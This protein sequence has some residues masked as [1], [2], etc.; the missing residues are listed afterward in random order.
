MVF[1][2]RPSRFLSMLQQALR[3]LPL[4]GSKFRCSGLG[5]CLSL[6]VISAAFAAQR[7]RADAAPMDL[8][9]EEVKA[10]VAELLA[11]GQ[12]S[13]NRV[14]VW[15]EVQAVLVK[16]NLAWCAQVPPEHV[17]THPSNR[18]SL[19]LG[20]TEAHV[21][22]AQ[23]LKTGWSWRKAADAAAIEAPPD[24]S[25]DWYHV[26]GINVMYAQLADGLLPPLVQLKLLSIGGGHTNAFLRAVKGGCKTPVTKLADASG[27]LN[28]EELCVGRAAFKEAVEL[29]MKWFIIH[30]H[31]PTVWPGLVRFAQAALNTDAKNEQ[32]EVEVMLDMANLMRSALTNQ[33]EPNWKQIEE[34]ACFSMPPCSPY[35]G[36]LSAI[37]RDH[38]AGGQLLEELS[39]FYK[40]FGCSEHGATRKLGAEFAS[41]L[42]SLSWG[43]GERFPFVVLACMETNLWSSKIVDGICK[44]ISVTNLSSLTTKANKSMVVEADELMNSVRLLCDGMHVAR[45]IR[46][47]LVGRCDV[48]CVLFMFKKLKEGGEKLPIASLSDVAQAALSHQDAFDISWAVGNVSLSILHRSAGG[49]GH[50]PE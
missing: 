20:A 4:D 44:L 9:T 29:G 50:R 35:I 11:A 45:A 22:G 2:A 21:H 30:C 6:S 7:A 37:V 19:G 42:A 48:R 33:S 8:Y 40:S 31:A 28:K 43:P 26:D 39:E 47:K 36:S 10:K 18:S 24:G 32:S 13:G 12:L 27:H 25:D 5:V 41:R 14:S 38:T 16:A 1:W 17:G 34:T 3:C 23:I 49:P 15:E 46:T